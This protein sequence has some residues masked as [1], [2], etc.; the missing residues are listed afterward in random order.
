VAV[1]APSSTAVPIAASRCRLTTFAWSGAEVETYTRLALG[2]GRVYVRL[3]ATSPAL[4]RI[5]NSASV[6]LVPCTP[7]GRP[8]GPAVDG[9]ARVLADGD[10]APARRAL[11]GGREWPR[12]SRDEDLLYVEIVPAGC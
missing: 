6:R 1:A 3:A 5:W 9:Q 11:A 7:G 12:L 4:E 2:E 8:T 10:D